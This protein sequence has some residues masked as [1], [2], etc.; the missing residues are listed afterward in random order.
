[1]KLISYNKKERDYFEL[2]CRSIFKFLEKDF[3]FKLELVERDRYGTRLIYKN[4]TTAV[5]IDF[6]PYEG[7]IFIKLIRL[8][9][10]NIPPYKEINPRDVIHDFH[11]TDIVSFRNPSLKLTWPT[12]DKWENRDILKKELRYR[13]KLI[14]KYASDILRGD[15]TIFPELEKIVKK[16]AKELGN[17]GHTILNS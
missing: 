10:N 5:K 13:A 1:M 6:T 9:N 15:F 2:L 16:R 3:T 11:L 4:L 14:K 8:V 12:V 7:Y 17:S